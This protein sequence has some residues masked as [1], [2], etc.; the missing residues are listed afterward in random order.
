MKMKTKL[1]KFLFSKN[2]NGTDIF[3]LGNYSELNEVLQSLKE[4]KSRFCY[5]YR[6]EINLILYE[7]EKMINIDITNY[8]LE[9]YFYLVLAIK[10]QPDLVNY[11]YDLELVNNLFNNNKG[12]N[13]IIKKFVT[14][15]IIFELAKNY[16]EF[17]EDKKI[18][19]I[20]N[21]CLNEFNKILNLEDFKLLKGLEIESINIDFIYFEI[22]KA[23]IINE[24]IDK[25]ED[26]YNIIKQIALENIN[27]TNDML[28]N[29]SNILNCES[30]VSKYK[31]VSLE[32][33]FNPNKINFNYILIRYILKDPIYIYKI[34]FL[35]NTK[36]FII[37][38]IKNNLDALFETKLKDSQI[39]ERQNYLLKIFTDSE[40]YYIKYWNKIKEKLNIILEYYEN[41]FFESKVNDIKSI[42]E[43]LKERKINYDDYIKD[44]EPAKKWNKKYEVIN[45]FNELKFKEKNE[46]NLNASKSTW[47]TLE[48]AIKDKKIKKLKNEDK[49][50]LSII[51][52]EKHKEKLIKI[53]SEDDYDFIKFSFGKI[54]ENVKEKLKEILNYYNNFYFESKKDDIIEIQNALSNNNNEEKI[55]EKYKKD[56]DNAT[57]MNEEYSL[58]DYLYNLKTKEKDIPRIIEQWKVLKNLILNNKYKKIRKDHK[59]K[60]FKYLN[61]NSKESL[62]KI[63]P[64]E[65]YDNLKKNID[66]NSNEDK[67]KEL[68]NLLNS[69]KKDPE[70]KKSEIN[71]I[72]EILKNYSD[73]KGLSEKYGN[74]LEMEKRL[75]LIKLF[76]DINNQGITQKK[77][78]EE[79]SNQWD[80]MEKMI[81]DKKI[82]KMKANL[83]KILINYFSD[84]GNQER[85]INIFGQDNYNFFIEKNKIKLIERK[86]TEKNINKNEEI[87]Q[88]IN[89]NKIIENDSTKSTKSTQS[90]TLKSSKKILE[91]PLFLDYKVLAERILIKSEI[92]LHTNKRGEKPFIIFDE[93]NYGESQIKVEEEQLY[94]MKH[95]FESINI[96]DI[97]VA[98][99]TKNYLKYLEFI[100]E[101][102]ELIQEEFDSNYNLKIK[103]VFKKHNK[104]ENS[105]NKGIIFNISCEYIFYPPNNKIK[106]ISF[107][108]E[109]ILVNKTNSPSQGFNFLILEINNDIYKNIEYLEKWEY[110]GEQ[111][112]FSDSFNNSNRI[113]NEILDNSESLTRRNISNRIMDNK[114]IEFIKIIGDHKDKENLIHYTAEFIK[115]LSNGYFI[116]GGTDS[117]LK[118]FTYRFEP[119][120][121]IG[122][123][124]EIKD[125]TYN[126]CEKSDY[127][128]KSNNNVQIISCSNKDLFL[129]EIDF[130]EGKLRPQRYELPEMTCNN[131]IEMKE[132]Q[133]II[134]GLNKSYFFDNIFHQQKTKI[135]NHQIINKTYRGC[136]PINDHIVALCSN[137]FA[138][139]G[140]DKLIIYN[141]IEDKIIY[142]KENSSFNF[143]VN[144]LSI[145]PEK[146]NETK[147]KILLCACKKYMP[148]QENGILIITN[149]NKDNQIINQFYPTGEF[150]VFT[151]CPL[152]ILD[153][154]E[155][156]NNSQRII[157]KETDYFLV[158]GFDIEK[159]EG[160]IKLYKANFNKDV[161]NIG[162]EFIQ[163]IVI[164][165]NK[166]FKGFQGPI[167]CIIQSKYS[168]FILATCY[169]GNV[170]LFSPPNLNYYMDK[171]IYDDIE[172]FNK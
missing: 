92:S 48:K 135:R 157:S 64:L 3:L 23:F 87:K 140:E 138:T 112:T 97:N 117:K 85:L 47:E 60:L 20:Q 148:D 9:F 44:L 121:K 59:I 55:L 172:L 16:S 83:K 143:S 74:V 90:K 39:K 130:K 171:D 86:K 91:D 41:Y 46:K 49:K 21:D 105:S 156:N 1:Q 113:Q 8:N 99:A 133:N 69:Y 106:E 17:S 18:E 13:K 72:E 32:D 51:F 33:F 6:K 37:K 15:K 137:K 144:A 10:D 36:N 110:Y 160:K 151:F 102:K 24:K 169:D 88:I 95:F 126:I 163:D 136:V 165:R 139:N 170:Y 82:N 79:A 124:K 73:Y 27:I 81:K 75:P 109:N 128:N 149:L 58:I 115:E 152:K 162:I 4:E 62:L 43:I 159:R 154:D 28:I 5:T 84:K 89:K 119:E 42:K 107:K 103:L 31:I 118:I 146:E 147:N 29:L 114:I 66:I 78:L 142:T 120:S 71:L 50:I 76:M 57:K 132:N 35:F 63:F 26:A 56:Y 80:Q 7:E 145:I 131:C 67:K 2:Y 111:S 166:S 134:I 96:N 77:K 12:E 53:F 153:Q 93:I 116:S 34:Q 19:F 14:S 94:K 123:I 168:L 22:I 104:I 101:I 129:I 98:P 150:E 127:K 100:E 158:G 108:E 38:L 40:Y 68:K 167:S 25:Y 155:F 52:N 11:S 30:Y 164:E 45:L 122:E 70:S 125:W 161:R 54:Q 65:C 61:E 141:T